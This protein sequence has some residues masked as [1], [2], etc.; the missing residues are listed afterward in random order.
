MKTRSLAEIAFR[1]IAVVCLIG[2]A[3]FAFGLGDK[4]S[5]GGFF[6]PTWARVLSL[7]LLLMVIGSGYLN[8]R[9]PKGHMLRSALIWVALIL[10]LMLGYSLM[11]S[12]SLTMRP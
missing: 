9:L 1:I 10:V 7:T 5:D 3:A 12:L 11:K 4:A 6:S 2:I 8:R